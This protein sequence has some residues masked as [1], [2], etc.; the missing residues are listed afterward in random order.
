[1]FLDIQRPYDM[2]K[3]LAP[4]AV[5]RLETVLNDRTDLPDILSDDDIRGDKT[6]RQVFDAMARHLSGGPEAARQLLEDAGFDGIFHQSQTDGRVWVAFNQEQIHPAFGVQD[7]LGPQG[8]RPAGILMSMLGVP[9]GMG[10][11]GPLTGPGMPQQPSPPPPPLVGSRPPTLREGA[12]GIPIEQMRDAQGRWKIPLKD[13]PPQELELQDFLRQQGGLNLDAETDIRGELERLITQAASGRDVAGILNNVSG[14]TMGNMAERAESAGFIPTADKTAL[15]DLMDRS[16]RQGQLIYSTQATGYVPVVHNPAV[17]QAY[18]ALLDIADTLEQRTTVQRR[19]E[20]GPRARGAVHEEARQLIESGQWTLDDVREIFP[21]TPLN[22]T[23]ASALVQQLDTLGEAVETAAARFIESGGR[24]GSG[25]EHGFLQA[26][27]LLGELDPI[28]LGAVAEGGRSLGILNDP[29]SSLNQR[30]NYLHQVLA[31]SPRLSSRNMAQKILAQQRAQPRLKTALDAEKVGFKEM[32]L[33]AWVNG[34][35][36]GP[37]TWAVNA[38][39]NTLVPPYLVM[40]RAFASLLSQTVGSGEVPWNAS[41]A[42]LAGW[43]DGM[44]DGWSLMG[45]AFRSGEEQFQRHYGLQD[46]EAVSRGD[47]KRPKAITAENVGINPE[48]AFG[49]AFDFWAEYI[50]LGSGGRLPTRIMMSTDELGKAV[51]YRMELNY[52]AALQAHALGLSTD[53]AK[54]RAVEIL[55]APDAQEMRQAA[56]SQAIINTF[57]QTITGERPI[58]SGL[59]AVANMTPVPFGLVELPIGRVLI[60]FSTT[61]ANLTRFAME[62]GLLGLAFQSFRHDVQAGGAQRDLALAKVTLG[63]MTM[64]GIAKLAFDG[65]LTGRGPEDKRLRDA[66]EA[67]GWRPYSIKIPN[68]V[69]KPFYIPYNRVDPFAWHLGMTADIVQVMGEAPDEPVQRAILALG[70]GFFRNL[71]N[72]TYMQSITRF[73]EAVSPKN[74]D[75]PDNWLGGFRRWAQGTLGSVVPSSVA[76]VRRLTDPYQREV[77]GLLDP[78]YD[79]APGWSKSLP[80]RRDKW[81][82]PKLLGWGFTPWWGTRLGVALS[83]IAPLSCKNRPLMPSCPGRKSPCRRCPTPCR[84]KRS[85]APMS[86]IPIPTSPSRSSSR[87]SST[88]A[89]FSMPQLM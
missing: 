64:V 46:L 39:S 83:P 11:L 76:T 19:A 38:L 66:L 17:M 62:R 51:S 32:F 60:P 56:G 89:T 15:L 50:G 74:Y 54:Q 5:E 45:K 30:L 55:T 31:E 78:I 43:G 71:T 73:F 69:G 33:E 72:R 68:P 27:A 6:G 47:L 2:S 57:Q 82:D 35:L 3:P 59:Q 29:L 61:P 7:L 12:E 9:G 48:S 84:S 49:K 52:L 63:T 80:Y 44:R 65:L 26:Y 1:M 36:S 21:G 14:K 87:R 8:F 58:A 41:V 77:E 20:E 86:P 53:E 23:L 4:E 88:T 70:Y 85:R 75:Q 37:Q 81:G 67:T 18:T 16:L 25:E 10:T 42:M 28:R 24:V 13:V 40:E 34:M 22:D 79:R